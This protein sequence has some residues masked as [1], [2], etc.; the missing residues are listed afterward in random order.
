MI[1]TTRNMHEFT[2]Q[3]VFEYVVGKVL[4]QGKPSV[5]PDRP[6]VCVYRGEGGLK[7]AVGHLIDDDELARWL[8]CHEGAVMSFTKDMYAKLDW[9]GMTHK[10]L[11]I[12]L[13]QCHD[14]AAVRMV[15]RRE[16]NQQ[17]NQLFIAELR[18]ILPD[19]VIPP[20]MLAAHALR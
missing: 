6:S 3:Q 11:L 10:E 17:F 4:E 20:E 13:Q 8:D 1:I 19:M 5:H 14:D 16:P 2:A 15:A 9:D 12:K 18:D 7:C